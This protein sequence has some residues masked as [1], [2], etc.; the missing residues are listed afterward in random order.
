MV[1]SGQAGSVVLHIPTSRYLRLN[2]RAT[3][4]VRL[5]IALGGPRGAV[6]AIVARDGVTTEAAEEEVASVLG[7]MEATVPLPAE[8][9]RRITVT[10]VARVVAAW[11]R[12]PLR[13]LV[14]TA[15]AAIVLVVAEQRLRTSDISRVAGLFRV[16]IAFEDRPA[17]PNGDDSALSD[18]ERRRIRQAE[19]VL[20]R[21]RYPATC[22]R[23]SLIVGLILRS[24]RPVLRLGLMPDGLTAHAWVEAEGRSYWAPEGLTP[25]TEMSSAA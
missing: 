22:L 10:R 17:A 7:P 14:G 5:V 21:W 18:N 19:W 6:Q 8:P 25:F 13:D 12:L 15:V 9:P 24:R 11:F 23:R 20:A 16:P 1:D 3:D 2:R 4:V